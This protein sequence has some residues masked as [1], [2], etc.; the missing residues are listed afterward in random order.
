[1]NTTQPYDIYELMI[2][3]PNKKG[4]MIY[5]E[6]HK[7]E[8]NL[9]LVRDLITLG[10]DLNW[11]NIRGITAL[12]VCAW[13]NTRLEFA[14][15]LI[16]AGAD[17]NITNET[18]WTALH[19]SAWYNR[20]EMVKM[21]LEAGSDKTMRTHSGIIPYELAETQELKELLKV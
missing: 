10:A 1:M 11:Q 5:Y 16:D 9:N 21:L 12:Q 3:S 15:I 6:T 18:G 20:T 19:W 13:N 8:P 14:R 2:I 7:P 4:E 17:L